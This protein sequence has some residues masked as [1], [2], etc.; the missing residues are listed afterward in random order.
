MVDSIARGTGLLG[1]VFTVVKNTSIKLYEASETKNPKYQDKILEVLRISPPIASKIQKLQSA[2][3]T[4][5]WNMDEIKTK[6]FSL[7]NPGFLAGGNVVSAATNIP[8]DRAVKKLNNLKA[9]SDS[10]IATYKRIALLMGWNEW[11]LGLNKKKKKPASKSKSR[12]RS[13]RRSGPDRR[14]V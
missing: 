4:A 14:S 5:S 6:G 3:R 8:L 11:E 10:E 1:A 9:A 7:D 12:R 2:G 13:N